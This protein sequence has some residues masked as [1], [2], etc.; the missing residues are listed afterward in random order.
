MPPIN[1]SAT[2]L[3]ANHNYLNHQSINQTS[4]LHNASSTSL[5]SANYL[6]QNATSIINN[7]QAT[8]FQSSNDHLHQQNTA[9]CQSASDN[10]L[11]HVQNLSNQLIS[12]GITASLSSNSLSSSSNNNVNNAIIK[13][14]HPYYNSNN[15]AVM[16]DIQPDRP[17]GYGAFGVVWAVTDPRD[18]KRVALKKMPNVFQ[19][20]VSAKR[21]YREVK[22]LCF[23]HH[24]NIVS[25]LD[26]LQ[27]P[28]IDFFQ[29]IYVITELM[30]SDLHK[31]IVSNQ[32]LTSDHVKIFLYQILRGLK[33]LHSA[34]ILHRDVKPGNLL[35]N[36]NCLLKICDFGLARVMEEDERRNMTQEVVTQYYR[37]PELLL[38]TKHYGA[39]IDIWSVG[40]I[41]AEL[42]G[43]RILFQAQTPIQQ[44]DLI[45]DLLGTPEPQDLKYACPAA[46]T[47][48][49]RKPFK[50]SA[51]N[52]LYSL[53]NQATVEAVHLLIQMLVFNP[54]KRISVYDALAHPYLEE[55]C[56]RYHSCMCKCCVS[57]NGKR[58]Y[59]TDLE[60]ISSR[61]FNDNFLRDLFSVQ[62]VKERLHKRIL[63]KCSSY[64]RVPLC[65][66]PNSA[67]FKSFASSTV[68][69][70]SELPLYD[71]NL[72]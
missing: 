43:R 30:Q 67:A 31:I 36:S 18:G 29:E 47:H 27:P 35:V 11:A 23:F 6:H 69:N 28:H 37:A 1:M 46:K 19:N 53:S 59:C 63:E 66:N 33:Y 21:V 38:G 70:L 54:D 44:L 22:M 16:Q 14:A 58:K 49:S 13:T 34:D 57:E 24:E 12:Q 17:I 15:N 7:H 3:S 5:G 72:W 26:L 8:N 60:P 56:L 39:A 64:N 62:Q 71:K 55:G 25:A 52:A 40:C 50:S 65:I 20:L 9:N 32:P 61:P 48:M 10:Q 68:A 45:T 51:V 42:L 41:F 4:L 2:S